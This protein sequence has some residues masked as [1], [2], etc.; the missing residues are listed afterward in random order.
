MRLLSKCTRFCR[1]LA[2]QEFDNDPSQLLAEFIGDT[3]TLGIPKT[4]PLVAS[5]FDLL[6]N[7]AQVDP[8]SDIPYE[9]RPTLLDGGKLF[10]GLNPGLA[11]LPNIRRED[12]LEYS[13][14]VARQLLC[15]KV[16]LRTRVKAG[17]DVFA[18][19]N[20]NAKLR[21]IWNGHILSLAAKRPP[22][23]PHIATPEV[24][25]N[26]EIGLDEL[27]Y[28]SKRDASVY[29]DQLMLPSP[30]R[31][32]FARPPLRMRD[33][34]KLGGI[35]EAEVRAAYIG[36]DTL[37]LGNPAELFANLDGPAERRTLQG[38]RQQLAERRAARI[39]VVGVLLALVGLAMWRAPL[40]E[41]AVLGVV[42]FFALLPAAAY[43]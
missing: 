6:D 16:E 23:P 20:T 13:Q 26:T 3:E 19:G 31:L 32:W 22:K 28:V 36:V 7:S 37:F 18:V 39:L 41:A 17:A 10:P 40:A 5:T 21:E 9:H 15:A 29:F 30:L 42:P 34:I 38:V 11:S 35:S 2:D 24:F 27:L 25:P 8:M 14:L 12:K 4:R 33:L 43:Y 1:R